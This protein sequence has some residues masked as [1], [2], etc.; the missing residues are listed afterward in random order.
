MKKVILLFL[1]LMIFSCTSI[2]VKEKP[3]KTFQIFKPKEVKKIFINL[4][5]QK[6]DKYAKANDKQFFSLELFSNIKEGLKEKGL[7]IDYHQVRG[8]EL[9]HDRARYLSPE[10]YLEIKGTNVKIPGEDISSQFIEYLLHV[11]IYKYQIKEKVLLSEISISLVKGKSLAIENMSEAIVN[12]LK[13]D[14]L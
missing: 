8:L 4:D 3:A 9:E 5:T 2:I 10:L 11:K 13:K 1:S 7:T 6:L 14:F 12:I